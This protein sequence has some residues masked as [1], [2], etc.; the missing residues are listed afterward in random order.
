MSAYFVGEVEIHDAVVYSEYAEAD[1]LI[2]EQ[3]GGLVLGPVTPK[4]S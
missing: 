3:Y 1:G 2:I 4:L